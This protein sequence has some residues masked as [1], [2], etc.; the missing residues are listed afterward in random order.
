MRHYSEDD[1][2][3]YYYGESRR[4]AAIDAHLRVCPPCRD[5]YH[6]VAGV[7]DVLPV[8][9]VPDRDE[10][11]GLD[12]WQRIR[13]QLTAREL[14]WWGVWR[15]VGVAVWVAALLIVAF[16]AG[17]QWPAR[18][19]E[20]PRAAA[21]L[22]PEASERIRLAAI[23]DHF[24]RSE[25]VLLDLVNAPALENAEGE[26]VDVSVQQAWA[27]ELIDASRLYRDASRR[28]GDEGIAG[29][30]DDLE[31]SLLEI[32]H[33]P[34]MLTPAELAAMRLRLD[35]TALLFKV[36][37]LSSQLRERELATSS[38]IDKTT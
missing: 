26:S 36:R 25:R 35:A 37:V 16:L 27:G 5:V 21:G 17:R 34:S 6:E 28:A 22:P 20:P 4:Q 9:E 31:R 13:H 11:Y 10:R 23:S 3:L 32:V 8:I 24:D 18:P 12:V 38:T 30:L 19:G 2:V 7:L 1:L 15:P 14:P 29:V 33:G